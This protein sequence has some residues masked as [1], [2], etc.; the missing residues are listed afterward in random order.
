MNGEL[1]MLVD[2]RF[3]AGGHTNSAGVEA[4][5]RLGDVRDDRTLERYLTGRLA[6][7]G[8]VDAA[9]AACVADGTVD[10]AVLDAEYS[11]R[12]LSPALREA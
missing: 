5:V 3:P 7:T 9:F 12:V 4:A 11:A 6:T 1:L 2:G 10:V 8:I